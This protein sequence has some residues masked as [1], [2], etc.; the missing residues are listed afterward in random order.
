[1]YDKMEVREAER[2]AGE[3]EEERGRETTS[4]RALAAGDDGGSPVEQLR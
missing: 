3:D 2:G 1:M 4:R